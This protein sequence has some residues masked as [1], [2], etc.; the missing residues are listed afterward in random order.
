MLVKKLKPETVEPASLQRPG[1]S[2]ARIKQSASGPCS[3]QSAQDSGLIRAGGLHPLV[4]IDDAH[5]LVLNIIRGLMSF[6]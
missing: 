3:E 2:T 6:H 1:P 5:S 4:S